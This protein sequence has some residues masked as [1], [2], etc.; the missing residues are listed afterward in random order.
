MGAAEMSG[1]FKGRVVGVTGAAQ[2]IGL[3]CA[4]AFCR[5]GAR[6]VVLTDIQ[7]E[8]VEHAAS[9]LWR[10]GFS[11]LAL[12]L[13]VRGAGRDGRESSR[14]PVGWERAGEQCRSRPSLRFFRIARELWQHSLDVMLSGPFY[15]CQAAGKVMR[16]QGGGAIVNMASVNGFVPQPR[17]CG[18]LLCESGARDAHACAGVRVGA[19]SDS[20]ERRRAPV[21][22]GPAGWR[23]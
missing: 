10:D 7:L 19:A 9:G 23:K 4:R 14:E 3:E 22:S 17:L 1:R 11:V 15:G 8:K 20:R 6:E 16:A 21:Q 12:A 13:D 18:I 5:E 2:S